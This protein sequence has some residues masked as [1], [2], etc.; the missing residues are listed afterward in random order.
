M[1]NSN[2]IDVILVVMTK[3]IINHVK[4][5]VRFDN[6]EIDKVTKEI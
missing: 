4:Y 2:K 1:Y 6:I 5:Q 3:I